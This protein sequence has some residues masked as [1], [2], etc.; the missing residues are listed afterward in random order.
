VQSLKEFWESRYRKMDIRESGNIGYSVRYNYW[1]Y[2]AKERALLKAIKR[3][4]IVIKGKKIA[5]IG[6]GTGFIVDFL[7]RREPASILGVDISQK[8]V[9][10]LKGKYSGHKNVNFQCLDITRSKPQGGSV[11]DLVDVYDVMCLIV[12]DEDFLQAMK[13]ICS[14]VAKPGLILLVDMFPEKT[15]RLGDYIVSRPREDYLQILTSNAF[16]ILEIVPQFYLFNR[17]ISNRI[18]RRMVN[19][20]PVVIYVIDGI[21]LSLNIFGDGNKSGASFKLL[22]AKRK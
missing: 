9:D 22:V 18:I 14:M 3:H 8:S 20:F 16:E 1:Y 21:A 7:L 6:S 17:N 2:R 5:D 10:Y 12:Q 4:G 13:H 19:L 15:V 11:Y